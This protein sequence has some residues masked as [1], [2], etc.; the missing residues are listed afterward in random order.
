MS[1]ERIHRAK[2]L[3]QCLIVNATV[4][5]DEVA[6]LRLLVDTGAGRTILPVE[7]LDKLGYNLAKSGGRI[8]LTTANGVV[9]A[10]LV[11]VS[12][13]NCLGKFA[14]R[15]TVAA[16]TIESGGFDGVLGMDFLIQFRAVISVAEAEIKF[17]HSKGK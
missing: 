13:F 16:H 7:T 5:G 14:K 9:V 2:W 10:P 12:W 15:F 1:R 6:R 8:H 4:G 17:G 3:G 11:R